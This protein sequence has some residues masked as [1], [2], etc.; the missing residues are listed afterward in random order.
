MTRTNQQKHSVLAPQI[1]KEVL[2]TDNI[3]FFTNTDYFTHSDLQTAHQKGFKIL[4]LFLD[5]EALQKRNTARVQ[6]EGYTDLSQWLE[7]MV[8]Y[9]K[10]LQKKRLVDKVIR[11]DKSIETIANELLS[12]MT[13]IEINI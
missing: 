5:L 9:Q 11:A 8:H 6:Q 4:Q 12:E 1:I 10:E 3:I 2:N 7:G 13:T